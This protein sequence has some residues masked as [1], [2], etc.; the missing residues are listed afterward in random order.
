MMI[1]L[2]FLEAIYLYSGNSTLM[3]HGVLS[4]CGH[5]TD[6]S[7]AEFLN[8]WQKQVSTELDLRLWRYYFW[9]LGTVIMGKL[10]WKL[11]HFNRKK[12]YGRDHFLTVSG[13]WTQVCQ[14]LETPG[15]F[16]YIVNKFL[17]FLLIY[18]F[19]LSKFG[20]SSWYL[21]LKRALNKYINPNSIDEEIKLREA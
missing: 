10:T 11:S 20:L 5:I 1:V 14:K 19:F 13:T 16:C 8:C 18:L 17:L 7:E 6:Q 9:V 4:R 21:P 2:V 3:Y 15:L 12:A